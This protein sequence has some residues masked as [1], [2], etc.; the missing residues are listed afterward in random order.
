MGT[1]SIDDFN[2]KIKEVVLQQLQD[3]KPLQ[4]K[5]S[6]SVIPEH[7]VFMVDY[8]SYRTWHTR[9]LAWK[10]YAYQVNL[11]PWLIKTSLNTSPQLLS[12]HCKQINK[13]KNG[14][15]GQPSSLLACMHVS[16]YKATF[17]PIHLVFLE[18]DTHQPRLD[19]KLLD[20][21]NNEVNLTTFFLQL[22]IKQWVYT[23][24]K[25]KFIQI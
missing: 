12:L 8:H 16:N 22:L 2:V 6:A 11:T 23:T 3:C 14:L 24:M 20:E 5:D 7:Y 21:S 10:D 4:I 17:S 13:V 18:L 19:F 15:D 1:Y 25:P 9:Q